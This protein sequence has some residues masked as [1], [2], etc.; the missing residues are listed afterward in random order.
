MKAIDSKTD[1]YG[2]FGNP[3]KHSLSPFLHNA[4]FEKEGLNAVYLAFEIDPLRL[5][6]AFDGMR[7]IGM[8]GAN[9]TL[10]FKENAIDLVDEIPEDLDRWIG[11]IN[12]VVL[13]EGRLFGYNTDAPGFLAALRE[14][15]GFKA[16]GKSVLLF[17]AGGAARAAAFALAHAGADRIFIHNRTAERAQGLRDHLAPHF[18]DCEIVAIPS[19]ESLEGERVDLVVNATSSGMKGESEFFFPLA[20][21]A[22]K[23]FAY[24]MV[25]TGDTSFLKT[26]RSLGWQTC[27]G[28]GMLVAQ[29]ALSFGLWTGRSEGVRQTMTDLLKTRLVTDRSQ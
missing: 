1:L 3:V 23:P 9:V 21:M 8:K 15:F 17:G 4:L 26:G 11:A 18:P 16:E 12:T 29:G 27:G 5:S 25:Y 19:V 2:I 22:G 14:A 28:L 20:R 24:D 10:P 6:Q 7:A 13:R